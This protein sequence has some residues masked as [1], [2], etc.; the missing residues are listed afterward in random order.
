MQHVIFNP[1]AG[2]K[3]ATKNL[4]T[5]TRMLEERQIPY[6]LHQSAG[7][8]D[9]ESIVRRLTENGER[10]II[11]LGG[12]GT[13]H[14]V[15]N[16]LS[17]PTACRLGLIPSGTGNDFAEAAGIPLNAEEAMRLILDGEPKDTD[18]IEIDGRRCMNV[19]GLGMDVD[20]L[21]RCQTGKMKGKL[22][23]LMSLLKSLFAF[24]GYGVT[25]EWDGKQEKH[26]ALLATVCNGSQFGGGISVCPT[27]D[28]QDGKLSVVVVDCIGGKWKIIKAF[29]ELMKG[30]ILEYPLTTHFLCDRIVFE[31]DLP[32]TVQLDGELYKDLRFDAK[33]CKGLKLYK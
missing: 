18:Y 4:R 31:P 17:D 19:A 1:V 33:I 16:G 28:I 26:D 3:K 15:L 9:A 11:A 6:E 7:V 2:K 22:K 12:D 10:D 23:Y 8:R 13:L 29:I 20:V 32:C 25:L 5:V 21:E 14:E 30:R 27:A 24:K